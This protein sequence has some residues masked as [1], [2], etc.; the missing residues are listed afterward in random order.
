MIVIRKPS[1]STLGYTIGLDG[2]FPS[3]S[4]KEQ[5]PP[6]AVNLGVGFY[7]LLLLELMYV[8]RARIN[9]P[10]RNIIVNASL[11]SMASPPFEGKPC[12]PKI[13]LYFLILPHITTR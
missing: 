13:Q 5:N 2:L 3:K 6:S 8:K 9:V 11:T 7:F 4:F 1:A 10:N 12:P